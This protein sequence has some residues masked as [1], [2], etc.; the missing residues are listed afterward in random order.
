MQKKS[1][2]F[3]DEGK[4]YSWGLGQDYQCHQMRDVYAKPEENELFRGLRLFDFAGGISH[5]AAIVEATD[6]LKWSKM[7]NRGR[8]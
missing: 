7:N 2:A 1:N 3:V 6:P 4:V 5:S 8:Y